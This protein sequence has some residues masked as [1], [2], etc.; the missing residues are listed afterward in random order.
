MTDLTAH[1]DATSRFET[2]SKITVLVVED[3]ALVRMNATVMLETAGY[4]VLAADSGASGLEQLGLHPEIGVL[5]TDINMPGDFD[6]LELARQVHRLRPDV[7]LIL[8]SGLMRP[9]RHELSGGEFI[10][11]PYDDAGVADLIR[12]AAGRAAAH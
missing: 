5:F 8:T 7:H 9:A 10:A 11:K 1:Q 12:V 3:E 6:G 2:A 4:I